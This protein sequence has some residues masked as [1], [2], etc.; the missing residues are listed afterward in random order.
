MVARSLT[1]FAP[2]KEDARTGTTYVLLG[3]DGVRDAVRRFDRLLNQP[4]L[5][6]Y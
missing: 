1:F 6:Y 3:V 5:Y 2:R 4:L